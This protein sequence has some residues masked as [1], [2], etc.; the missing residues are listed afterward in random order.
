M[1][2]ESLKCEIEAYCY[3]V[4]RGKPAAMLAIQDKHIKKIKE[5][6]CSQYKQ[7]KVF[8]C[9]LSEGWRTLWIYKHDYMI[10]VIKSL[11][12]KPKTVFDHWVLGKVFGYSDEAIA[13]FIRE[14]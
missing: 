2:M 9:R 7:I 5:Y 14:N 1:Y 11:P 6:I 4:E 13:E 8:E 3:M 10:D 12:E